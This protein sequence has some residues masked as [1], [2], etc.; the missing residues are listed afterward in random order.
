MNL[1]APIA[2]AFGALIPVLIIFYL[3]KVRRHE[4]EVSSTFLWEQLHR[5]LVAHEPWQRLKVT[6]LLILQVLLMALVTFGLAR[7][8]FT[9]N[10]QASDNVVLLLDAS[11]SMQAT[12][13]KPNRFEA[14]RNAAKDIVGRLSDDA[15]GTIVRVKD[16]PD[17]LVQGGTKNQ[18][19][20]SLNH[21]AVTSGST[22]MKEALQLAL[23]LNKGK[24]RSQIFIISDGA[25][26]AVKDVQAGDAEIHF[27]PIG[28]SGENQ[29]ITTLSAR[30]DPADPRHQQVFVRVQNFG[31]A[32]AT[33]LL[34]LYADGK[35]AD[36]ADLQL[37]ARDSSGPG[38][39]E[40]V[41]DSVPQGT[42]AVEARLRDT[43]QFSADKNAWLVLNQSTAFKVLL[44]TQNNLFLEK[45]INLLPNVEVFK[46]DPR[47]Y[48]GIDPS[49]YSV[50]VFDGFL[51]QDLPNGNMLLVNPPPTDWLNISSDLIP[52]PKI[53]SFEDSDPLLSYVQFGDIQ[54]S[55]TK[56]VEPPPWATVLAQSGSHPLLLAGNNAGRKMVILPFDLHWSNFG[57]LSG[58]PIFISNVM[59]YLQPNDATDIKAPAPGDSVLIQ[60]LPQADEIVVRKPDGSSRDFKP[61]GKPVAYNDTDAVGLYQ[62][63]QLSNGKPLQDQMFAINLTNAAES[64]I[65][66]RTSLNIGGSVVQQNQAV[67]WTPAKHEVWPWVL[68]AAI[69]LLTFEWYWYHRHA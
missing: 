20:D 46:T 10:A 4:Q 48:T 39:V 33:N 23:S 37:P 55:R 12:D 13:V 9:A 11:A 28:S 18:L 50:F 2:L 45:A 60:P 40:H 6:M 29:G 36:S 30:P 53:T 24:S 65:T 43:G 67:D 25:F 66:P 34:S 15:S 49:Q 61:G 21:A 5:D 52:R 3:L 17:I 59:T 22:N 56:D 31:T 63:T 19:L 64:D 41:F 54:L 26:P 38:T 47:R 35:L 8:F 68:L 16:H 62:V 27:V 1:V 51:P 7:P 32:P 42:K 14:A 69:G 58:F 44:V 57:L